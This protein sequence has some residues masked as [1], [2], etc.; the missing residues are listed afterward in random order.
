[1]TRRQSAIVAYIAQHWQEHGY[2]P[3]LREIAEA[4][5]YSHRVS[6]TL[7]ALV[8]DGVLVRFQRV[9]GWRVL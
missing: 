9:R 1:M 5:G 4:T 7:A 6:V 3:T 8:R 2:S